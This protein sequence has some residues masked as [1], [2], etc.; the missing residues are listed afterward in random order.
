MPHCGQYW[1][2]SFFSGFGSASFLS[3]G[4]TS[5]FIGSGAAIKAQTL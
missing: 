4:G 2:M 3:V 5:V 1:L